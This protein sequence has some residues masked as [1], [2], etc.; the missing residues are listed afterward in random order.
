V[1]WW[2]N[3]DSTAEKWTAPGEDH[4]GDN[5]QE[6]EHGAQGGEGKSRSIYVFVFVRPLAAAKRRDLSWGEP[7]LRDTLRTTRSHG[8]PGRSGRF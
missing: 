4:E 2:K 8:A 1:K 6:R 3:L 7:P 5:E